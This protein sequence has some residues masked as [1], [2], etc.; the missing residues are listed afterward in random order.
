MRQDVSNFEKPSRE[1]LANDRL[2]FCDNIVFEITYVTE[3]GARIMRIDEPK[4]VS[5]WVP[6]YM[7]NR[8]EYKGSV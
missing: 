4:H 1:Y 2:V 5:F 6:Y 7:L 8:F 3:G